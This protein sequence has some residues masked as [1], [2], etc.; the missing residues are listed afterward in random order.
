M[1]RMEYTKESKK[2]GRQRE[3]ENPKKTKSRKE[4]E[5]KEPKYLRNCR[6][7]SKIIL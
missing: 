2:K 1:N 7:N 4:E 5:G 6:E 3:K